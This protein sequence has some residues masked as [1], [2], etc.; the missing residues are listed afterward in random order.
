MSTISTATG[1]S[2]PD[3]AAWIAEQ[4]GF[5]SA[6]QVQ[7]LLIILGL[8]GFA[9]LWV[10]RPYSFNPEDYEVVDGKLKRRIL[11]GEATEDQHETQLPDKTLI[12]AFPSSDELERE[13]VQAQEWL[14]TDPLKDLRNN[15][16]QLY[17]EWGRPSVEALNSWVSGV[18]MDLNYSESEHSWAAQALLSH[19]Q[20]DLSNA[21]D[22]LRRIFTPYQETTEQMLVQS[23]PKEAADHYRKQTPKS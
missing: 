19:L 2:L 13:W 23:F 11:I 3:Q 16:G 5:L 14:A 21:E 7:W 15:I 4:L 9:F 10:I 8:V 12:P 20:K 18:S 1:L 17:R 6:T 22:A